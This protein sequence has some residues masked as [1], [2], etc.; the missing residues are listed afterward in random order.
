V[1]RHTSRRKPLLSL[2]LVT[3]VSFAAAFSVITSAFAGSAHRAA[4]IECASQEWNDNQPSHSLPQQ[5][6]KFS[7]WHGSWWYH[8]QRLYNGSVQYDHEMPNGGDWSFQNSVD[9]D[10]STK[11]V[12]NDP[13][14]HNH[15]THLVQRTDTHC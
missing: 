1:N 2:A 13:Q 9:V 5:H 11:I 7:F 14:A 8:G 6:V 10:R 4:A 15:Y 3:V 12:Y